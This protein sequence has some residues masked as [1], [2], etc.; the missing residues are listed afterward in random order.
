MKLTHSASSY[1]LSIHAEINGVMGF[2]HSHSKRSMT[3]KVNGKNL[4]VFRYSGKKSVQS[5]QFG[6]TIERGMIKANAL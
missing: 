5:E 3:V 4:I 1:F 2:S 6:K